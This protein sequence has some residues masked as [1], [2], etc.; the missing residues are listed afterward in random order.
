[1]SEYQYYLFEY[2]DGFLDNRQRQ[3]LRQISSCAEI[4]ANSFQ[5]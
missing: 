5:V 3:A 2:R 4:T 1:M